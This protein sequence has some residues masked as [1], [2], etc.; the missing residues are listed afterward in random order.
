VG[1]NSIATNDYSLT[2]GRYVDTA[3]AN[4]ESDE[5]FA[6]KLR[7]IHDELMELNDKAAEFAG[8]I[9]SNLEELLG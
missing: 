9:S 5:V 3:P 2:P 4:A 1:E 6:E 7:E 8:R